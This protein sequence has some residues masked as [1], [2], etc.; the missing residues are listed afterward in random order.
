[1]KA[2]FGL[3]PTAGDQTIRSSKSRIILAFIG[4]A[5]TVSA[6][7]GSA[8]TSQRRTLKPAYKQ[9]GTP[10]ASTRHIEKGPGAGPKRFRCGWTDHSGTGPSW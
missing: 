4:R 1:M 9:R 6:S 8:S 7:A 2:R 3:A 5:H 10:G